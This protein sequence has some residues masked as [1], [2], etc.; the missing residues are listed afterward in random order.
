MDL[1]L[2]LSM[3]NAFISLKNTTG[4]P[5]QSFDFMA[6][7]WLVTDDHLKNADMDLY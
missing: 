1:M 7:N 4:V 3:S 5:G 2:A 6:T